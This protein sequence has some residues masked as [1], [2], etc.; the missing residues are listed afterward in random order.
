MIVMPFSGSIIA[1]LPRLPMSIVSSRAT[2]L[3]ETEVCW[4][5]I[6]PQAQGICPSDALLA[7]PP[8]LSPPVIVPA[9][10]PVKTA[11]TSLLD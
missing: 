11:F 5:S 10:L 1:G 3:Q 9:S 8:A 7:Y 6:R 4:W 2:D